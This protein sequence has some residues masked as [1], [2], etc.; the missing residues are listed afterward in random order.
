MRSERGSASLV[1]VAIVV[2]LNLLRRGSVAF[3]AVAGAAAV[4]VLARIRVLLAVAAALAR[5]LGVDKVP[6]IVIRG[7]AKRPVRFFGFPAGNEFPGFIETLIDAAR[8]VPDLRPET[9]KQLRK[10]KTGVRLQVMVTPTCPYCPALARTALKLGL[11][12]VRVNADVVEASEF[13]ALVQR[14]GVRAVPTTVIDERLVLPG[15]MEEATL[16]QNIFRV[17]EGKPLSGETRA[18]AAT[19]LSAAAP[20]QSQAS[21]SGLV[22]PR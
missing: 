3:A 10:L 13:P 20:A 6:G 16:L 19:A 8:G 7:L 5:E 18:G 14:Y 4:A 1:A 2:A 22:L 15:A 12:S 21:G 9:T 17:V 11:G